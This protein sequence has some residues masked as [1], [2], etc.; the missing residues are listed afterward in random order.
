MILCHVDISNGISY[1]NTC[2]KYSNFEECVRVCRSLIASSADEEM[3]NGISKVHLI[4][5]KA[6]YYTALPELWYLIKQENGPINKEKKQVTDECFK[7]MKDAITYLGNALDQKQI[8][9]EGS[10]LLDFALKESALSLGGIGSRCLLCRRGGQKLKKSHIWPNSVINRIYKAEYDGTTRPFLFGEDV[11]QPKSSSKCTFNMFCHRCEEIL[12]QNGEDQYARLLDNIQKAPD[13]HTYGSWLYSFAVGIVFRELA[14]ETLSYVINE[15]ELYEAYLLCRKHLFTL[16]VKLN[17]EYLPPL[18]KEE[19]FQF[20]SICADTIGS[21]VSVYILN[22]MA[23]SASSKNKMVNYFSEYC[24]CFGSVATCNLGDAR[25]DLSGRVHFLEVYLNG[26]HFLVKFKA[27]ES[28]PISESLLIQPQP[29][30]DSQ[31][32]IIPKEDINSIP[33]GVWSVLCHAG[34]ISFNTRMEVYQVMSDLTLHNLT[35]SSSFSPSDPTIVKGPL[36]ELTP[37]TPDGTPCML[38]PTLCV[39]DFLPKGMFINVNKP[40]ELPLHLPDKHMVVL[41]IS[42]G[43]EEISSTYFLCVDYTNDALNFYVILVCWDKT[44][45]GMQI[46]DGFYITPDDKPT[47][48]SF[49]LEDREAIWSIFLVPLQFP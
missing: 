45:S 44:S 16:S 43:M 14:T 38:S 17:K 15:Q 18:S 22:C 19:E 39:F 42:G 11:Y 20:Q 23:K 34:S 9:S 41:H 47:V 31:M 26:F 10:M 33:E 4:L 2:Y 40:S 28:Y 5:G 13:L 21:D 27:S 37:I 36:M 46:I 24:H 12:S 49:L 6:L 7:K 25:L 29:T 32:C 8:D 1:A 35:K 30:T 48:I 3:P